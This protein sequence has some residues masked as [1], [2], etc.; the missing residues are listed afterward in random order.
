MVRAIRFAA[1]LVAALALLTW[2]ASVIV[3]RTTS[4]WFENYLRLRAQLAVT[5]ARQALVS[6]WEEES[7]PALQQVLSELTH[8]ERILAAAACNADLMP[9]TQTLDYPT[10]FECKTIGG[11]VRTASG[12]STFAWTSWH[13]VTSLAGG[14]MHVSAIPLVDRDQALGFIVLVHDLS[15]VER[16]EAKM[17]Q[18][19]L[20]AFGFLA[21][22]TS[23]VTLLAA[24]WSWAGWSNELRRLLQGDTDRPEFRPFVR[25]VR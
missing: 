24:R 13:T 18:F 3:H 9:L 20:V 21:V 15:Y 11:H 22:A 25:D 19:L 8:D 4:D 2:G 14:N 10:G 23:V 5:G 7:R 17:R 6:H 16:R 12:P 1:G